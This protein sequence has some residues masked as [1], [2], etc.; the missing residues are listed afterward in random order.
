MAWGTPEY[1]PHEYNLAGQVLVNGADCPELTLEK[2]LEIINNWR[3]SHYHPLNT[4]QMRLRKKASAIDGTSLV[5][6]RIKRLSSIKHKMERFDTMRLVQ[7][8]DIGGCRAILSTM[9]HLS[10]L[11]DIYTLKE[12]NRT[13]RGIKHKL[14]GIKDYINKPPKTGYRGVH[15]IFQYYSDKVHDYDGL[16]IEIQFRTFLQ[17]AWAT[18]VE[19]VG[20]FTGQALKSN[21][22][23]KEWLRFFSLA[24]CIIASAEGTPLI[25]DM[26]SSLDEIRRELREF[27]TKLDV[28]GQLATYS[29]ALT[30]LGTKE[31]RGAHFYLLE[32]DL[33]TK[34]INIRTYKKNEL[35]RATDD[36]LVLE[37]I[38]LQRQT[39]TVLVSV[40]SLS[41]LKQAYPNYFADTSLFLQALNKFIA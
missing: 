21:L 39:N 20:I 19:I 14:V 24:S 16:K 1:Q 15:L 27:N 8:Q 36:Y 33:E 5:A 4:I 9:D 34:T 40:D 17:H 12:K 30:T 32:L 37:K 31:I 28:T 26:P 2:S 10:K 22:G 18:A 13:G 35:D 6:Q 38:S 3:S 7:I 23:E 41:L 25:P 11:V 29:H